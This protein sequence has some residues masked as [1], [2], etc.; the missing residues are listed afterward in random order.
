M[1]KTHLL[2]YGLLTAVAVAAGGDVGLAQFSAPAITPLPTTSSPPVTGTP[3]LTPIPSS[4]G[5]GTVAQPTFD[6]Y[7]GA[8]AAPPTLYGTPATYGTP[9]VYTP[10]TVQQVFSQ[11]APG[12]GT[13]APPVVYPGTPYAAPPPT[14]SPMMATGMKLFQNLHFDYTFLQ[15]KDG[16]EL[17]INDFFLTS[18]IAFPNFLWTGQPWFISPGFGLHLWSGPWDGN[19]AHVLPPNAYSAFLDL[20]YQSDPNKQVGVELAGRIGVFTDFE[21]FESSESVRPSGVAL[22]RI[23]LSPTMTLKG[24]VEYINRADIKIF[25]AGGLVW[26]PNPRTRWD[27][28]FPQPKLAS[29]LATVGNNDLWGYLAGEYGG[30]VWTIDQGDPYGVTLFD[31]DDIRVM[32]G[33]EFG[34]AGFTGIGKQ[35]GF[36]EIGYVFQ[37][38]LVFVTHPDDNTT[39]AE[40]FMLRGG[41]NF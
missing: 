40:T 22:L 37:R 11:P 21:T 8:A 12:F 24:G 1:P 28:Y 13:T 6:P 35:T 33:L 18:T 23:N 5:V 10:P 32:A 20:G 25:P 9:G 7:G 17:Q 29:Y 39:L 31:I 27:I 2:I 26:T 3:Q 34:A 14:T 38:N 19:P 41:F 16:N 30:G 36:I 15:G 4:A